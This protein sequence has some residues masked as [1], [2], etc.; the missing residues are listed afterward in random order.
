MLQNGI[1]MRFKI[2]YYDT[3]MWFDGILL[4]PI[5]EIWINKKYKNTPI[6]KLILK[7]ELKHLEFFKKIKKIQYYER[8]WLKRIIKV[9]YWIQ[10]NNLWDFYDSRRLEEK[11]RAWERRTT[12][13]YRSF[14]TCI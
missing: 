6:G 12:Q 13:S 9:F 11:K 14:R 5:R 10:Y 1:F 3:S 7:H 8:N 2:K 4:Y